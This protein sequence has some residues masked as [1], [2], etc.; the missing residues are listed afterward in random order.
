MSWQ[1]LSCFPGKSKILSHIMVIC[2]DKCRDSKCL[3]PLSVFPQLVLLSVMWY[4]MGYCWGLLSWLCPLPGSPVSPTPSLVG[5]C[6]EQKRPWPCAST[7]D[8][9]L[10]H[11]CGIHTLLVTNPTCWHH[12]CCFEE[13]ELCPSLKQ[14]LPKLRSAITIWVSNQLSWH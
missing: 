1:V 2:E 3:H 9:Q 14:Q 11:G 12:T 5:Q 4:G 7:A 10:K 8:H 13:N 6:E